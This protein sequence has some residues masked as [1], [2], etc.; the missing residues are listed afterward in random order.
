M[1]NVVFIMTDHVSLT[2]CICMYAINQRLFKRNNAVHIDVILTCIN[3]YL[4]HLLYF[5]TLPLFSTTY[6][7]QKILKVL[8]YHQC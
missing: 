2:L 8:P 7:F 1:Y 6:P 3:A 4:K 5:K